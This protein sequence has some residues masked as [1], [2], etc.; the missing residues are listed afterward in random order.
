MALL[1]ADIIGGCCGT[2]PDYIREVAKTVDLTPTVKS[3]ETFA[4][5]EN[6]KPV[7]KK[8][9]SEMPTVQLKI[10]NLLR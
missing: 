4:N 6:E 8:S 3:D 2:T 7:I 5:N 10:K 9:F 1:G